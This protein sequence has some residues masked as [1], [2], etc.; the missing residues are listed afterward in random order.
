MS[1]AKVT[2]D[3]YGYYHHPELASAFGDMLRGWQ[4]IMNDRPESDIHEGIACQM[5]DPDTEVHIGLHSDRTQIDSDV[6]ASLVTSPGFHP[7]YVDSNS[8]VFFVILTSDPDKLVQIIDSC[9]NA[10]VGRMTPDELEAYK[11]HKC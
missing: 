4:A 11:V 10:Q 6:Q 9:E 1:K 2:Q 3:K 7:Y 5:F 8:D